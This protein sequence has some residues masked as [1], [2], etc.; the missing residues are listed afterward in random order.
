MAQAL[1]PVLFSDPVARG[2]IRMRCLRRTV[3]IGKRRDRR[4]S[5]ADFRFLI[6]D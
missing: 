6:C 4:F 5:I 1:M 2:L 3:A